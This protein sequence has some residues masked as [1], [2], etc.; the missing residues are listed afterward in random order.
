ML[1]GAVGH[2]GVLS[3]GV[4]VIHGYEQGGRFGARRVGVVEETVCFGEEAVCEENL[5]KLSM[6]G[7]RLYC[8][9]TPSR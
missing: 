1:E 2:V 5:V 7:D 8:V 3:G 6:S 9:F 4:V